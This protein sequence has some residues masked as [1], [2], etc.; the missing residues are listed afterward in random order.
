MKLIHDCVR[1]IMLYIEDNLK[2][3]NTLTINEIQINLSNYSIED[4]TYTCEKLDEAG[5]LEIKRYITG[6]AIV[7]KMTYNGHQ[8][9]DTIRDDS[10][11]KETKS[12]ISKI[13]GVSLPIIQQVAAQ[14]ISLKLGII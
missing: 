5:Y 6:D 7:L 4:I 8:F 9:L 14:L 2:L 1:D 3:D 12:K 11:W 13:A 10:I